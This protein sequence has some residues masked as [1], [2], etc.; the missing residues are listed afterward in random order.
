MGKLVVKTN[1]K[2]EIT[3]TLEVL[4]GQAE[5]ERVSRNEDGTIDI[6]YSGGTTIFWDDQKTVTNDAGSPIYL[7]EDGTEYSEAELEIIDE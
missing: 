7:D 6:Q 1:H 2:I 4:H 5:I 3:G